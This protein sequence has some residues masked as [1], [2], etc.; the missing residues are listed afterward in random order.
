M[1]LAALPDYP[2]E[3]MNPYVARAGEHPGGLV[4]LSIGSPVDQTPALIREALA[5]ATDAHAYPQTVGTPALR[6]AIVEWFRRR[7]GVD[8][9]AAE[10]VLPTIGSKELV[11]FLPFMLGLGDGDA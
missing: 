2:W 6:E 1:T 10:N 5:S 4:D 11:A 9:L 7:R 3:Q 8:G